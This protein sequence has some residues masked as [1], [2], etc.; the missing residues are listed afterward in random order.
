[1]IADEGA[2]GGLEPQPFD[3]PRELCRSGLRTPSA[4]EIEMMSKSSRMSM[5]ST[6]P[7]WVTARPL[8]TR[9]VLSPRRRSSRRVLDASAK[10]RAWWR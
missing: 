4:S 1:M 7:F 6:V 8:V 5:A 3:C 2:V 10:G 9:P